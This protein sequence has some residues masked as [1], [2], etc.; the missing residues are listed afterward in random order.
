MFSLALCGAGLITEG[1]K[2][3]CGCILTLNPNLRIFVSETDSQFSSAQVFTDWYNETRITHKQYFQ[4]YPYW[5]KLFQHY[6]KIVF[7]YHGFRDISLTVVL[8]KYNQ[9]QMTHNFPRERFVFHVL[10]A[11]STQ[12]VCFWAGSFQICANMH[13][14]TSCFSYGRTF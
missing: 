1:V 8:Q 5:Q 14:H 6:S 12:D 4:S 10:G 7:V 9:H 11:A 2:P 13:F 3:A